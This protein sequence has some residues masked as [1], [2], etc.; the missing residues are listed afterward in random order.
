[1][2]PLPDAK[3]PRTQQHHRAERE[4]V[5]QQDESVKDLHGYA[6]RI[7]QTAGRSAN[8]IKNPI[9]TDLPLE[10]KKGERLNAPPSPRQTFRPHANART[11]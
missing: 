11:A 8:R 9:M 10:M 2:P 7:S 1:M 5:E 6:L 4:N 3:K